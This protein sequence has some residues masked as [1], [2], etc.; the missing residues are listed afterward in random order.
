MSLL[1]ISLA[2]SP[3]VGVYAEVNSATSTTIIEEVKSS[4]TPANPTPEVVTAETSTPVRLI[5]PVVSTSS[6]STPSQ[7]E[8]EQKLSPP[9]E[10]TVNI[11]TTTP[12]R[13]V[14]KKEVEEPKEPKEK[15]K[16]KKDASRS[17]EEELGLVR[18]HLLDQGLPQTIVDRLD[19]Y[20]KEQRA[21]PPQEGIFKKIVNFVTGNTEAQKEA[22][23]VEVLAKKQP[24]KVEGF[25]G[26][27]NKIDESS[28][29]QLF[30]DKKEQT[31]GFFEKV[32]TFLK[33][34]SSL[35]S[36]F[37]GTKKSTPLSWLFGAKV[38][39]QVSSNPNDYLAAGG[40]IVFSKAIQDKAVTLGGDPLAMLNFVRNDVEYTP[41]FGSKKGS[42]ATL[43]ESAGNDMDKASLLVAL[44]RNSGIPARYR[45][46]D[47]QMD[48]R[49]VTDLLGVDSA[50]GAAQV[51]SLHKI[52][53]I[54]YTQNDEPVFFV[55][56]HTYVEAYMPYGY[57]RGAKLNDGGSK[58]WVPMDPTITG[59]YYERPV[60]L[61]DE[62]NN[63]GFDVKVFFDKYLKGDYG[64]AIEPLEA[65]KT[66]VQGHLASNPPAS[67]PGLTYDD[68]LMRMYPKNQ[69][70]AFIPA[71]LPYQ[72][73]ADLNT[74]DYIPASLRHTL[75]FTVKSDQ[76]AQV[77]GHSAYLSDLANKE[78][79]IT[80]DAAT[81]VDQA[82]ID[83]FDTIYDVVPLSLVSVTTKIK[84]NGVNIAE[85]ATPTT[86]GKSQKYVM[87]F[88]IPTREIGGPVNALVEETIDKSIIVGNTDAIGLDTG[89][90]VP[91]GLRPKEDIATSSFVS[92]QILYDTA[93][94]YL[95]R[96]ENT[97]GELARIIGA[98]FSDVA[99]RAIIFNGI[100][101][102]NKNGQPYSFDWK[103]LRIDASAKVKYFSRFHESVK[104][105]KKEFTA[106]F[107]LQASQDESDVFEDNFDV[108]SVAT[109][110][111]L[112]LVSANTFSGITLKKI[113]Q[114]NEGDIDGLNVTASTKNVFHS[115]I[116]EG[117]TIYTPTAPITYGAWH[118]L[119]YINIDFDGGEASYS[120]GEGLN[121]GYTVCGL[122]GI[123]SFCN[124]VQD[125]V[126]Y[127]RKDTPITNA[128]IIS[129]TNNQNYTVGDSI[130]FEVQYKTIVN[131][132]TLSQWIEKE[133][134]KTDNLGP[135]TRTL[136]TKY[137]T[138]VK[139]NI[140][141][142][143]KPDLG[144]SLKINT[145]TQSAE[146]KFIE[147]FMDEIATEYGVEITN[148]LAGVGISEGIRM[149]TPAI[150][151]KVGPT[152]AGKIVARF[153][154]GVGWVL[155]VGSAGSIAYNAGPTAGKCFSFSSS[156][157]DLLLETKSPS[158]FCGKLTAQSLFIAA[159]VGTDRLVGSKIS[160]YF[161]RKIGINTII[162]SALQTE[163]RSS[164]ELYELNNWSNAGRSSGTH[165][166]AEWFNKIDSNT[167]KNYL[168]NTT[169]YKEYDV[170]DKIEGQNR[171]P[172]RFV[173]GED[174][175]IYFT[176]N[177]YGD[178]TV[179]NSP[180]F[181]KVD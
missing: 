120:I 93:Q 165:V 91:S 57:S 131:G 74:Y 8:S 25:E 98:D 179:N 79:L 37:D 123:T 110:K 99:T 62:M 32:K 33:S 40:E 178:P 124:W 30:P 31:N 56:E 145:A 130:N 109:V 85:S 128:T 83:S 82:T 176:D 53:Y 38:T 26:T 94:D 35:N 107:G 122:P 138:G 50:I 132:A 173:K 106:V 46:V 71:T 143:P 67:F 59:Y 68:A 76:D 3:W 89:R 97:E 64:S 170:Y 152:A 54:L 104:T 39:A 18:Q 114:T 129:P 174:G 10:S 2:F 171:G 164:L 146:Q 168:P 117:N 22:R 17:Q 90:V 105:H 48:I 181:V 70:T 24:F 135:G 119:F 72:I 44:L 87:E 81:P 159:G 65:F 139:V 73:S 20:E 100:A 45:H 1:L 34:G 92:G 180:P 61:I 80:F 154:P 11:S 102:T 153:I 166:G 134:I 148:F 78:L 47:A 5:D 43:V 49:T 167:G 7:K 41:Y 150:A 157:D 142:N 160:H 66:L 149:L 27:I 126:D 175:S 147:G 162:R 115:A 36:D 29:K 140:K 127:L 58:Q 103:G 88:G 60:D 169:T 108:E 163:V 172:H 86:L 133:T 144:L 84:V 15:V 161:A 63:S 121:G 42:D 75:K 156:M 158:Y 51:L 125:R 21:G 28:Y 151:K 69:D 9:E 177:H 14:F 116:Q 101:V 137:G 12:Q 112:K 96:L 136:I 4:N 6:P 111:G 118:G 141:L 77:L 13:E 155:L 95:Y 52:P 19:T 113:N 23:E 55:V 16:F